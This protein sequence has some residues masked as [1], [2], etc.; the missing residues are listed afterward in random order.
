MAERQNY[1]QLALRQ[2][3]PTRSSFL[4][5]ANFWQKCRI[6]TSISPGELKSTK[7]T[8]TPETT[9]GTIQNARKIDKNSRTRRKPRGTPLPPS[10]I[11]TVQQREMLRVDF[12]NAQAKTTEILAEVHNKPQERH[13]CNF[14]ISLEDLTVSGEI[15]FPERRLHNQCVHF[16]RET[17]WDN[18]RIKYIWTLIWE[19]LSNHFRTNWS[20]SNLLGLSSFWADFRVLNGFLAI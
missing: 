14:P 11:I 8:K 12:R 1:P 9:R 19:P 7:N 20:R 3:S 16:Q 6:S 5:R 13:A 18:S 2:R 15:R 17:H 10:S 4:R